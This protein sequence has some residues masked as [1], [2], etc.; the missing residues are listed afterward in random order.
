MKLKEILKSVSYASFC[1]MMLV[2]CDSNED[3]NLKNSAITYELPDELK[4]KLKQSDGMLV[5]KTNVSLMK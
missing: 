5:F 1:G 2:C 4:I 3:V